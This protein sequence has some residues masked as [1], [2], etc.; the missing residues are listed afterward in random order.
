MFSASPREGMNV[1][2]RREAG[3]VGVLPPSASVCSSPSSVAAAR[4]LLSSCTDVDELS[5]R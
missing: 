5:L 2:T 1:V 3:L 4:P